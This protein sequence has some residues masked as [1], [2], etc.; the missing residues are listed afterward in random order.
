[1]K[2]DNVFHDILAGKDL[3]HILCTTLVH[4][5][6][7]MERPMKTNTNFYPKMCALDEKMLYQKPKVWVFDRIIGLPPMIL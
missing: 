4:R 7:Q 2:P 6:E 3:Q 1:M 5:Q